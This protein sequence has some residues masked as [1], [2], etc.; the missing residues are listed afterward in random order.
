MCKYATFEIAPK[1][2][3]VKHSVESVRL[4]GKH[5]QTVWL[6]VFHCIVIVHA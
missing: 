3:Y 6:D 2:A 5:V 4:S 1:W